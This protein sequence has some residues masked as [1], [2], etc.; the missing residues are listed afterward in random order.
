METYVAVSAGGLLI[1]H[2][3]VFPDAAIVR[4][5]TAD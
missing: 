5:S 4:R 2:T 1:G 3:K